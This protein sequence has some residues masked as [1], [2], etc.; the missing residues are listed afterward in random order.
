[1]NLAP[2]LAVFTLLL[3]GST[4][5]NR[6]GDPGREGVEAAT[7]KKREPARVRVEPVVRR[8]MLR[9][10]ETTTRVESVNQVEVM[11][12]SSGVV[13]EVLVE[14][15]DRIASGQ[16][17]A[18]IDARQAVIAAA[19]SEFA[20]GDARAALP[21]LELATREAEARLATSRRGF[22]QVQRDFARN[23]KIAASGPDRPALLSDK[24]LDASRL[25]RDNAQ[26]EVSNAELA[27]ERAKLEVLNGQ[28]AVRRAELALERARLDL[29]NTEI[30]APFAGVLATRHIKVGETL[31]AASTAFTL[32]DPGQLRAVFYRPQRELA[33]FLAAV[34][35]SEV[36]PETT[37]GGALSAAGPATARQSAELELFATAEALPGRRFRGRIERIS[38]T[39][40]PQS[41]N[42]RI[43]A[44]LDGTD[45]GESR[46]W[47]LPG[48]LVRL[49]I[50]TERRPDTLVVQKRALRREG[51]ANLVFVVREGRAVRVPISEGLSDDECLEVL[52]IGEARLEPGEPVVVV[53]NRDLED[54]GEVAITSGAEAPA[55]EASTAALPAAADH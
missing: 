34:T 14:E 20:L 54:G 27:V 49:E 10:L 41:G 21:R 17:L 37:P 32:T 51:D 28:A 45:V 12:R 55:G 42:F 47:L 50:I 46:A 38:P 18:R 22:E 23:E 26:A 44:R 52:P 29:S 33:L 16:V 39:I 48:M 31:N 13:T 19:D 4:A 40:D 5:C 35:P 2:R 7:I 36:L 25:A 43:T 24:D 53:G 30:T 1:M 6:G 9:V 15:G 3:F 11:S 8:E